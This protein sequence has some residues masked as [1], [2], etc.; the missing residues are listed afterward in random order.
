MKYR[1]ILLKLSG[2]SLGG[3]NGSG[4]SSAVLSE[5]AD[6]IKSITS[7]GTQVAVVIGGGNIF[8][9]VQGSGAGI[10][11]IQG[12]YMGMLATII[13]SLALQ[14]GLENKGIS[15]QV[16]SSIKIG[17]ITRQMTSRGAI[18][19]LDEGNVVIIGGGTGNPFFTTDTSGVLRALEVKADILLKATRVN[20]VYDK[21]PEKYPDARMFER[22]SFDEAYGKNLRIMD[23]TAFAL[24]R[25]NNL[26][27]CVFNIN[28]KGI[29]KSIISGENAGTLI[30]NTI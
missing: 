14:S 13:N 28:R 6:E 8:R 11:R 3:S 12:D 19:S 7:V 2:E 27:V 4:I 21:D 10:D 22:L 1:R 16:F 25:E 17:N 15:S 29:L 20:G 26:D 9:G 24:C 23:L 30:S 5:F 18:R